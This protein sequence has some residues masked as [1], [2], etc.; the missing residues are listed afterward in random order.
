MKKQKITKTISIIISP[1]YDFDTVFLKGKW[2]DPLLLKARV[3]TTKEDKVWVLSREEQNY[4]YMVE[5][6]AGV[7][8]DKEKMTELRKKSEKKFLEEIKKKYDIKRIKK[9]HARDYVDYEAVTHYWEK[10]K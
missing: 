5:I 2:A 9:C 4:G 8:W 7:H 1:V 3:I 6:T 10:I